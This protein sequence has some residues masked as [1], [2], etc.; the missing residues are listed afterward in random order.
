MNVRP[1]LPADIPRLLALIRRYWDF[2]GIQGFNA[3]RV[4]LVLKQLLAE[5]ALGAAW[6]AEDAEE[7]L[8]YAIVVHVLSVEHQGLMAEIDEFFV[9]PE[10][11]SRGIGG[12]LLK[13]L[14]ASLARHG[15][16][17]LQLQLA[18]TNATARA[19]YASRGYAPREGYELLD[20]RLVP[21][22]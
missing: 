19:F 11:R 12:E 1:A 16:V 18:R 10:A 20:K 5:A 6:V 7:L 17:R 22:T 15:Y 13:T 9:L 2:E 8:G 4:E 3:L 14:E 21:R